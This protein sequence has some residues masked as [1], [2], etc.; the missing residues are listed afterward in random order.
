M[1]ERSDLVRNV[2]SAGALVLTVGG[3]WTAIK[4]DIQRIDLNVASLTLSFKEF[5]CEVRP[6]P[7]LCHEVLTGEIEP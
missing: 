5:R 2:I 3:L 6:Q 1:T 4:L 7:Y